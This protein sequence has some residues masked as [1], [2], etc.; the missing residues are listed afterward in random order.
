LDTHKEQPAKK[1]WMIYVSGLNVFGWYVDKKLESPFEEFGGKKW[2]KTGDLGFLDKDGYLTISWRL[3]RFVKIAWEMI[4]LPA[5]ETVLAR[6]WK[7]SDG[8]ECLAIEAEEN[9]WAVKLTLFTTEKLWT[10]EVND[11]LHSQWVTNL[12]SI[13]SIIQLKEIPMLGTWK[14]DH[15][16]LKSILQSWP[17]K[18]PSETTPKTKKATSKKTKKE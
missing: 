8:T 10:S 5:I 18:Q 4:S 3:K 1:E 17:T 16:Q 13:T 14:V 12:V 11:Y 15:V 9:D 2:Y 7:H 6:K